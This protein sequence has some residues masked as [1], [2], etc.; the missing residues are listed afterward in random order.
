[1]KNNDKILIAFLVSVGLFS[2]CQAKQY[3]SNLSNI[4]KK[5]LIPAT[6]VSLDKALVSTD[7][8]EVHEIKY[9]A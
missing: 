9:G 2:F 6:K 7:P 4:E 3:V 8:Y 1:M 5:A